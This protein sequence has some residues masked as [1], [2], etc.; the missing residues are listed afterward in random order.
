[1]YISISLD[2][3]RPLLSFG[4]NLGSRNTHPCPEIEQSLLKLQ[5]G[6]IV[7]IDVDVVE[8]HRM[9]GISPPSML[10]R[11]ASSYGFTRLEFIRN[12]YY[13]VAHRYIRNIKCSDLNIVELNMLVLLPMCQTKNPGNAILTWLIDTAGWIRTAED[14][15]QDRPIT[16]VKVIG[17][18]PSDH[19]LTQKFYDIGF[20]SNGD[21]TTGTNTFESNDLCLVN[22]DRVFIPFA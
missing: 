7:R 13:I 10:K 14:Y 3:G 21:S 9:S 22:T 1:M 6:S 17:M 20:D 12:E 8:E 4:S 19:K 18:L 11:Q 16:G 5:V 2:M 15:G